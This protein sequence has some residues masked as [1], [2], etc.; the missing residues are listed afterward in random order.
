MSVNQPQERFDA[1]GS[2]P[3][4]QRHH[5]G[6]RSGGQ[7]CIEA[8]SAGFTLNVE[9]RLPS[10]ESAPAHWTRA[11]ILMT[12][13][14]CHVPSRYREA[15]LAKAGLAILV[16]GSGAMFRNMPGYKTGAIHD[17][18]M[19][20]RSEFNAPE[21]G[22]SSISLCIELIGLRKGKATT[23]HLGKKITDVQELKQARQAGC[24][25]CG[26]LITLCHPGG[27]RHLA[28]QTDPSGLCAQHRE[29]DPLGRPARIRHMARTCHDRG[30]PDCR[31]RP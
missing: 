7:C 16:K 21:A 22:L 10:T 11:C 6:L 23:P 28:H 18:Q 4:R 1:Q 9:P 13:H 12:N 3:D 17:V 20:P 27:R 14:H 15:R 26:F 19:L 29:V 31:A 24:H 30:K 5:M 2:E 8:W 25:G